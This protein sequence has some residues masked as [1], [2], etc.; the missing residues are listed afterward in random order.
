MGCACLRDDNP[1]LP[2]KLPK[3]KVSER[4]PTTTTRQ[5][6]AVAA[7]TV[8]RRASAC[9]AKKVKLQLPGHSNDMGGLR[10]A[11]TANPQ[12]PR[13]SR[14]DKSPSSSPRSGGTPSSGRGSV[15]WTENSPVVRLKDFRKLSGGLES[16]YELTKERIGNLVKAEHRVTRKTC[17]LQALRQGKGKKRELLRM[18]SLDHPYLLK[19]LDLLEDEDYLYVVYEGTAGGTAAQFLTIGISEERAAKIMRQVF[20]ALSYCHSKSLVYKSL[21]PQHILFVEPP[22]EHGLFVKVVVPCEEVFEIDSACVA[23]EAKN[24][25]HIGPA[26][27][28]WSCGMI[29]SILLC[30][31]YVLAKQENYQV[32]QDFKCA[33]MKWQGMSKPVKSLVS[34]LLSKKHSKRPT[35][36]ECLQH[37]WLSSSPRTPHLTHSVRNALRHM[38]KHQ[39]TSFKR[40]LLQLMLH[41]VI[42]SEELAGVRVAYNELDTNLDGMLSEA[43]LRAQIFRLFPEEQAQTALETILSTAAFSEDRKLPYSEFLLWACSKRVFTADAY[44]VTTF[45]L[46][47]VNKDDLVT[48]DELREVFALESQDYRSWVFL[49]TG[50][51][52]AGSSGFSCK[53][54]VSFMQKP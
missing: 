10:R 23:P 3:Q 16:C 19:V 17:W 27:D 33:Y 40:A 26:N 35:L 54:F 36:K 32:S 5:N 8:E 18:R 25:Q 38:T 1:S 51:S 31:Q 11:A 47:D 34:T 45:K 53:E 24:K 49:T 42:P 20:A 52:T 9:S 46:L 44:L 30:G 39:P 22:A 4:H 41:F 14:G 50:I 15:A 28:M 7:P 37:P 48:I 43:E 12:S 21:S 2:S 13:N 6:K 29:I